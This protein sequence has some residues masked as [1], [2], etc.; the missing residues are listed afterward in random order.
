MFFKVIF[1]LDGSGLYFDPNEPIHLDALLAYCLA[2]RL[3]LK[4]YI[5]RD[6]IPEECPLPLK[7]HTLKGGKWVWSGSA[8]FP[9]G[10]QGE[11]LQ[12][13][14]KRFR[15]DCADLTNGSPNIREGT[16]RDWN[17]PIPL[18]LTHKMIAYGS[19]GRRQC[20]KLLRR[21]IKSLGKKRAYGLG[22]VT[23]I[24][25][26]EIG[27]NYSIEKD[28]RAMRWLPNEKGSRLVRLAPPYWNRICR[29]MCCE[30]GEVI[31]C[32]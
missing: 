23:K 26:I 7:K 12:F 1:H 30:V 6:D 32:A 10:P 31:D 9:E 2:P 21:D 24:E 19:G 25:A 11:D 13:W 4:D 17:M 16:Y 8:L 22:K 18:V 14:R 29:V 27:K 15:Q 20:L 3:G 28:G 5:N